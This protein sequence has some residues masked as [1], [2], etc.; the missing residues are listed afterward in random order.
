MCKSGVSTHFLAKQTKKC[1]KRP[2]LH[3]FLSFPPKYVQKR[4]IY[5]YFAQIHRNLCKNSHF[6]QISPASASDGE[7]S[8]PTRPAVSTHGLPAQ[9]VTP[10]CPASIPPPTVRKAQRIIRTIKIVLKQRPER[11]RFT[12]YWLCLQETS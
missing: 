5:T 6:T 3:I 7:C 1:V 8:S 10:P 12:L 9:A 4:S 2:V 11:L